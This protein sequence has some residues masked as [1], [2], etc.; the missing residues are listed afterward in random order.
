VLLNYVSL[1]LS[2]DFCTRGR[3]Q[4]T[5]SADED[6]VLKATSGSIL[7]LGRIEYDNFR[8]AVK[9]AGRYPTRLL[10]FLTVLLASLVGDVS[11]DG[12]RILCSS[13]ARVGTANQT[14]T[15]QV[16][17]QK[18]LISFMHHSP[19]LSAVKLG[20]ACWFR[21]YFHDSRAKVCTTAAA[22][23]ERIDM[24]APNMPQWRFPAQL[25]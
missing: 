2:A 23:R 8:S 22:S 7:A 21:A 12:F 20:H 6:E 14:S 19:R 1:S 3:D 15:S 13:K 25:G 5:I 4:L 11:I 16:A 10:V 24:E 9:I 18:W 17:R